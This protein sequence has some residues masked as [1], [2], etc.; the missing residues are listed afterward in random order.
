MVKLRSGLV[1][2]LLCLS[3]CQTVYQ[4]GAP[5]LLGTDGVPC[6]GQVAA[7]AGWREVNDD[8]LLKMALGATDK[9]GICAGKVFEATQATRVYRVW[10]S[11]YATSRLGKW[12]ALDQPE[13]PR[14]AYRANYAIC[15]DWSALDEETACMLQPGSRIVLGTTQSAS[16]GSFIYPKTAWLQVYV[17]PQGAS[18]ESMLNACDADQSWPVA[19]T[20][21]K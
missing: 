1:F 7:P 14:E 4:G 21:G 12:W 10:D 9:G 18:V 6:D 2:M 15:P 20:A 5:S 19:G 13:S 17:N 3:G 8:A 11:R 16:C